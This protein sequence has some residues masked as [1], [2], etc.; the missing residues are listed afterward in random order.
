MYL[1]RF[2]WN[3]TCR[4][5]F[6]RFRFSNI[7]KFKPF[8]SFIVKLFLSLH[9]IVIVSNCNTKVYICLSRVSWKKAS[10]IIKFRKA[11]VHLSSNHQ[12]SGL[13]SVMS[14]RIKREC[15]KKTWMRCCRLSE[16]TRLP[17]YVRSFRGPV[18]IVKFENIV[19]YEWRPIWY[20]VKPAWKGTSI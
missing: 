3:S 6:F 5:Y 12:F 15:P 10:C 13:W 2:M 19:H 16:L 20:T 4:T 14:S 1:N 18:E 7:T 17:N 8:S 11:F 9:F